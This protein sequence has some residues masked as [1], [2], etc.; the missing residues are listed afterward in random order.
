ME[1]DTPLAVDSAISNW[2]LSSEREMEGNSFCVVSPELTFS[3]LTG[4]EYGG[5]GPHMCLGKFAF[6]IEV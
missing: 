1:G 2:L 3:I 4:W 5:G 6:M